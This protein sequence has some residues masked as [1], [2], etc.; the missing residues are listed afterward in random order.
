MSNTKFNLVP[1]T[2]D[3]NNNA[4]VKTT[5]NVLPEVV[6]ESTRKQEEMMDARLAEMDLAFEEECRRE[7]EDFEQIRA[8]YGYSSQIIKLL[9][10]GRSPK[11]PDLKSKNSC[12]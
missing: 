3:I 8:E 10:W 6:D 7:E 12:S 11:R 2:P 1:A 9:G 5:S 4:A